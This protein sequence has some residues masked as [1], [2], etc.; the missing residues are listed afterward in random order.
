MA[1]SKGEQQKGFWRARRNRALSFRALMVAAAVVLAGLVGLFPLAHAQPPTPLTPDARRLHP[2]LLRQLLTASPDAMLPV[3]VEWR[4]TPTGHLLADLPATARTPQQRAAV[5]TALQA[6]TA[7]EGAALQRALAN[8]EETG[9]AEAVR[10]FWIA[11]VASARLTPRALATLS[12]HPDVVAIRPDRQFFL[13]PFAPRPAPLSVDETAWRW[14]LRMLGVDRVRDGLGLDGSGVVVANLDT[15]VD[16]QHP[17]LM[18]RYR[19]YRPGTPAVHVGNWFDVTNAGCRY[20]CDGN[21]HGTH[22]MGTM[23]GVAEDGT[24]IGVAPGAQWIAVRIFTAGGYTYES[25]IHAAFE[26]VMAPNGDPA[27]APDVVNNSWGSPVADDT[28]FQPDVAALRAAGI[29]P[30]FSAGNSGPAPES[31]QSPASFPE[32]LAVGA[33]D[34]EGQV[35]TFSSRGPSPWNEIKPEVAAPGVNIL[36]S[37]PGGAYGVLDGT[38]MA[39]PHVA[40]V[41]ALLL[42]ADPTLMPDDLEAFLTETA[43]PLGAQTPNNATGWGL[44]NAEAAALRLTASGVVVGAVRDAANAPIAYAQ[45]RAV[46]RDGARRLVVTADADGA[47]RLGL[48]AGLYDIGVQ[49]FG[50]LPLTTTLA[51]NAETTYTLTHTLA[52]APWGTVQGRV[53]DAVQGTPLTATVA[54]PCDE[55]PALLAETATDASGRFTLT[56]PAGTW[57]LRVEAMAHRVASI[58][59]TLAAG[60]TLSFTVALDP[61]PSILLV[62]SGAWYYDSQIDFFEEALDALHLPYTLHRIANPFG[63]RGPL[64]DTP[65]ADLLTAFDVVIWSAP[66]DSP[67]LIGAERAISEA[68]AAGA[69]VLLTG[70]DVAYWD[71]G[72]AAY[73][74]TYYMLNQLGVFFD[75]EGDLSPLVGV[76][77]TLFDG[78]TLVFNTSDSARQQYHPDSV[79]VLDPRTTQPVLTWAD[80]AIGGVQSGTCR[81]YRALWLGGGLEGMGDTAARVDA[82]RRSLDWLAAEPDA[83]AL[84][85]EAARAPLIGEAGRVVSTSLMLDNRGVLTQTLDLTLSGGEW[86]MRVALPDGG[87]FTTT[88]TLTLGGCETVVLT[89]TVTIPPDARPHHFAR[90][91]LAVQSRDAPTQALTVPLTFKTPAPVLVIDDARWFDV[92]TAYTRTLDALGVAYDLFAT[93]GEAHPV[94]PDLLNRAR[95]VLWFTAY[96]WF[97][98]LTAEEEA[99]L[100]D[101]LEAG[102]RLILSSQEYLDLRGDSAFARDY[103]GVASARLSVSP[104]LAYDAPPL[105]VFDARPL[106]AQGGHEWELR[107]PFDNFADGIEPTADATTWLW[108]EAANAI[109][110]RR[111]TPTWRTAFASFPLETLPDVARERVLAALL[112]EMGPFAEARLQVPLAVAAGATWPLTLTV[113]VPVTLSAAQVRLALPAALDV[114][115]GSVGGG[116]VFDAGT[117]R[118]ERTGALVPGEVWTLTAAVQAQ[119]VPSVTL[120]ATFGDGA[121]LTTTQRAVVWVDGAWP[122][123]SG[124]LT[125]SLATPVTPRLA[126]V[127]VRNLGVVSTMMTLTRAMGGAPAP[128][129]SGVVTPGGAVQVSVPFSP[130]FA[131]GRAAAFLRVATG[132]GVERTWPVQL[133]AWWRQFAPLVGRGK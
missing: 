122:A 14:N 23:V 104:T 82:L 91:T 85:A 71:A 101:F 10:F 76:P 96:D 48:E 33:V 113:R 45:V 27:L 34:E 92:R 2:A 110:V 75:D 60:Q 53:V 67:A 118:L 28:A 125:P 64:T 47:Y 54:L 108:D 19:G 78:L 12:R 126:E 69:R 107:Y 17:A 93:E 117:R 79:Q 74:Y 29:L 5:I 32:S 16:W 90:Y 81:P 18:T 49:A 115:T 68:L 36:S 52:R 57:A 4:R 26:W 40:G 65:T 109:G 120:Q 121:A 61:A 80:G 46:R 21:G 102:G 87:F 127:T 41:A 51:V 116:W 131:A 35:A 63:D 39:A 124:R 24:P 133:D 98:P 89:P 59:P 119:A 50:Y 103:L 6:A 100:A 77:G 42:Q 72:G 38:S 94:T 111:T 132:E 83:Y 66:H 55:C 8:A 58:T 9:D 73:F 20:P 15:G 84:V 44:V 130:T 106:D 3:L 13:E 86:P 129:W 128:A 105:G 11:P 37:L 7:R 99:M 30:I 88:A 95:V 112:H 1:H 123:L 62:D 114:V 31:I 22:T 56:L 97:S 43:T 70:Q 25:W